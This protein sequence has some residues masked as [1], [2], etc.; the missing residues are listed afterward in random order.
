MQDFEKDGQ[1]FATHF[2]T[3]SYLHYKFIQTHWFKQV[4]KLA[5]EWFCHD[6]LLLITIHITLGNNNI[7]VGP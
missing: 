2:F 3:D 7:S 6:N 5:L 1:L 4:S